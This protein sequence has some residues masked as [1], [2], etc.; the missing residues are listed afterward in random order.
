M[1]RPATDA[2]AGAIAALSEQLGYPVSAA[3]IAQEIERSMD[4]LGVACKAGSRARPPVHL[5]WH[6]ATGLNACSPGMVFRMRR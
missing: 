2:D 5:A 4:F 6:G 1:I 3:E